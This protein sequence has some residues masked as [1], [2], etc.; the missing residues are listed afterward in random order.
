MPRPHHSTRAETR[1][2]VRI[3]PLFIVAIL[4]VATYSVVAR[5]C[6]KFESGSESESLEMVGERR[7]KKRNQI[8]TRL[9]FFSPV[10]YLYNEKHQSGVVTAFLVL[11]FL[12]FLLMAAAYLR[13][14]FTTQLN[15]GLVPLPPREQ[16]ERE[17]AEKLRKRRHKRNRDVEE[18]AYTPPDPNP[19]S[20][21]LEAFYSKD[22]FVCEVDGRPKWCSECQQWKPDRSHHSSDLG[23]CVRKMDH[24]CPWVGG[25][26]SETCKI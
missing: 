2:A 13:T 19:D 26:V 6:S 12:F 24:F 14:F 10:D 18:S 23:R 17:A 5:L 4:G 21:G 15:P 8:L 3:I 16:T 11:Y 7:K 25:M 20:P 1:W 22:V 9:C